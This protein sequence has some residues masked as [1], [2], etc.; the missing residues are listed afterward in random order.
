M[1]SELRVVE[2]P[3]RGEPPT[4][5]APT[6]I[7]VAAVRELDRIQA[8]TRFVPSLPIREQHRREE[9]QAQRRI[10][11]RLLGRADRVDRE[12]AHRRDGRRREREAE[13]VER[14]EPQAPR[15]PVPAGH[16][17]R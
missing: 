14:L 2:Q 16:R 9:P 1:E 4:R 3:D 7:V 15:V 13:V 5:P 17:A 6:M 11:A 12:D 8:T 10:D